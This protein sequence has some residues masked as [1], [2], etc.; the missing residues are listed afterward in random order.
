MWALEF[1]KLNCFLVDFIQKALN[2]I[3]HYINEKIY[4]DLHTKIFQNYTQC[5]KITIAR[6]NWKLFVF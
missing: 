1:S 5:C 3:V 6:I 4:S 2:I